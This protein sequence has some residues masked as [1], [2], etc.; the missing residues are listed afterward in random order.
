MRPIDADDLKKRILK[1]RD[2]IPKE[3]YD[4]YCLGVGRPNEHGNSMRGGIRIALRCMENT[5]TLDV[6]EVVRCKDCYWVDI[7]ENDCGG[8]VYCQLHRRDT[9]EDEY[10]SHGMRGN[11]EQESLSRGSVG[12]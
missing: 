6:V 9:N 3:I 12:F 5:P 11:A 2:A 1:E 7:G 10:C 4:R 8:W